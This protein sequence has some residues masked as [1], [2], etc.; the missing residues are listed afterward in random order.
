[1]NKWNSVENLPLPKDRKVLA[2]NQDGEHAVVWF[3]DDDFISGKWFGCVEA[4]YENECF[5]DITH[6]ME[7]PKPPEE[8]KL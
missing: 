8:P 3:E 1:M 4:C 6:W 5:T 2:L 7:L